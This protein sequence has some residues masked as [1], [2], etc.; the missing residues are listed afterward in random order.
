M[1]NTT[2][3]KIANKE[4]EISFINYL[5]DN[6]HSM[7]H[8]TVEL[9]SHSCMTSGSDGD[10]NGL[11]YIHSLKH[12]RGKSCHVQAMCENSGVYCEASENPNKQQLHQ[13]VKDAIFGE[14]GDSYSITVI[15]EAQT[16]QTQQSGT[17]G[18]I[19]MS[20]AVTFGAVNEPSVTL[21]K[22]TQIIHC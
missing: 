2:M 12:L 14:L 20:Q 18:Q 3:L 5:I 17:N 4:R 21:H 1:K 16:Q 11:F 13:K 9:F 22:L 19:Y 6:F 15:L 10:T 7:F 8:I